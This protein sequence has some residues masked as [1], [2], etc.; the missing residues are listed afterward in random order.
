MS[1]AQPQLPVPLAAEPRASVR[2]QL[3]LSDDHDRFANYLRRLGCTVVDRG[4]GT[5]DVSV[6]H[7]QSVGDEACAIAEWCESWS[8]VHAPAY[9]VVSA[10]AE[11]AAT[12]L[13][14]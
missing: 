8:A 6:V 3:R 9:A 5:F 13:V 1:A 4:A 11:P 10:T 2:V 14:A 7:R 12:A